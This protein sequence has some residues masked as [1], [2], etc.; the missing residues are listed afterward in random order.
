MAYSEEFLTYVNGQLMPH[1]KATP[2]LQRISVRSTGGYYDTARTFGGRPFKLRQHIERLFNG[3]VY[4]KIDPGLSID[5]LET[6]SLGVV[7]ANRPLLRSDLAEMTVTQTITVSRPDS[8]DDLP[9][10][11]VVIYCAQIDFS[12]FARSYVDGVGV[13]TPSTYAP[14]RNSPVSDGKGYGPQVFQLMTNSQ[15]FVTECQGA[16]FMFVSDGRIKLP[17]RRNVLPGVSMRTALDIADSLGIGVDEGLYSTTQIYQADEAFVSSTRY[18]LLPVTSVNG[19]HMMEDRTPGPITERLLSEWKR[20][21]GIDFVA[22]A[23]AS[24]DM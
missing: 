5:D 7:E 14:P 23:L 1:S 11:D 15:G 12:Q 16:N 10:V 3:L 18:C 6:A 24:L 21:V 4:S 13:H 20:L 2:I 22:H 8:A 19:Y 17:D 9:T